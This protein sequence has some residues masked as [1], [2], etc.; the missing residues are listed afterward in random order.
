MR[1]GARFHGP[2]APVFSFAA[3][4]FAR[5]ASNSSTFRL[6]LP[7]PLF[8]AFHGDPPQTIR[9]CALI[10]RAPPTQTSAKTS[11]RVLN[12]MPP[13]GTRLVPKVVEPSDE[14]IYKFFAD[15]FDHVLDVRF[16][17]PKFSQ[18]TAESHGRDILVT[19][20]VLDNRILKA[21]WCTDPTA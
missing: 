17:S 3:P 19:S 11:V 20:Q 1:A 15:W 8:F 7:F 18:P 14:N 5:L 2:I 6:P 4:I 12:V 16:L 13:S 21:H 10:P 9:A